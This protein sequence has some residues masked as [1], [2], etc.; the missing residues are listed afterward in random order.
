MVEHLSLPMLKHTISA[1]FERSVHEFDLFGCRSRWR[2]LMSVSIFCY[3]LPSPLIPGVF[4]KH[5]Q[6]SKISF[7]SSALIHGQLTRFPYLLL[8]YDQQLLIAKY[9]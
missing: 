3:R 1:E 4:S 5:D 8:L 7:V 9:K 6:M 2:S